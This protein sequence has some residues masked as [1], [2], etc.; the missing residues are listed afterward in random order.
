M[1]KIKFL[2]FILLI[3]FF[4]FISSCKKEEGSFSNIVIDDKFKDVKFEDATAL[5]DGKPHSIFVSGL[6][7]EYQVFYYGNNRTNT[8]NYEVVAGITKDD[9]IVKTLKANLTIEKYSDLKFPTITAMYQDTIYQPK[10]EIGPRENATIKYDYNSILEVPGEYMA[11]ATISGGKYDGKVYSTNVII[12]PFDISL[13]EYN[14]VF[15]YDGKEHK[16]SPI[17]KIPSSL[18]IHYINNSLKTSGEKTVDISYKIKEG[19][20]D[21]FVNNQSVKKTLTV[22][23]NASDPNYYDNPTDQNLITIKYMDQYD[24]LFATK[25]VNKYDTVE[26]PELLNDE[27]HVSYYIEHNTI[28]FL[29]YVV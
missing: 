11:Y 20:E 26:D 25:T 16:I 9:V 6:D 22:K 1:K 8:G 3:P 2:A 29:S 4:M 18:A 28:V 5:Y 13:I 17:T 24:N 7:S 14:T 23:S 27:T 21:Y 12:K 10:I 15:E 19:Y